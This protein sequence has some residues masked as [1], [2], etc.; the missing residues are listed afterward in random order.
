MLN[1]NFPGHPPGRAII[2]VLNQK[3][4]AGKTTTVVNLADALARRGYE[5]VAIDMDPQGNLSDTIGT[6]SKNDVN[7]NT[8]ALF[9]ATDLDKIPPTPWYETVADKVSLVYGH[10]SLTKIERF[11]MAKAMPGFDL[12]KLLDRMALSDEHIVLIDCP[13]S[14]SVLTVNALVASD[15]CLIPLESGSQYSLDG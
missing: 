15:Y 5:I 7:W 10:I 8:P 1:A 2:S 12:S 4:G 11:L 9:S 6:R 3:G 13:P 14:L